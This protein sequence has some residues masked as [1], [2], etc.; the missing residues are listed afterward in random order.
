MATPTLQHVD[1]R[2]LLAI[3]TDMGVPTSLRR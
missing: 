2:V 1:L 3:Y